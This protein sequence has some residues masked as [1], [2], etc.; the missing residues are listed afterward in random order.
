M[1]KNDLA[2]SDRNSAYCRVQED[3]GKED[4]I[5]IN[6]VQGDGKH[7]YMLTWSRKFFSYTGF[8]FFLEV[9]QCSIWLL[10]KVEGYCEFLTCME[11][12][13]LILR[14]QLPH[15]KEMKMPLMRY[16]LQLAYEL[17]RFWLCPQKISI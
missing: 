5:T 10:W 4:K 8:F 15:G 2:S 1:E 14:P 7:T 13:S 12:P 6:N 3:S 16:F 11:T 17:T 9:A